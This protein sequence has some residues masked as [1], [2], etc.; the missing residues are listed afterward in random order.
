MIKAVLF[1]LDGTLLPMDQDLFIK[2]YF[3]RLAK[4]LAKRGYDPEQLVSTIWQGT[5]A[6]I[7]NDGKETNETVFWNVF[8]SIFGEKSRAD[9]PYFDEFYRTDFPDVKS[10]C[11]YSP[12]SKELVDKIK[13]R[14]IP[15]VLATNP[16]FPAIATEC[17]I[18]WAGLSPSD[19]SLCTTYENIGYSK[20]NPEYYLEIVRRLGVNADEC[21]MVGNDV[22]DDMIAARL[23][24]KV[25]LLTD[26]LINA[27]NE[28][29]SVYPRGNFDDLF[30]FIFANI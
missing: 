18:G 15:V 17:R 20:P 24:M 23:G 12:R 28:D 30:D 14:G 16:I 8:S 2:T 9:E 1:D 26:C 4:K 13:S 27:K 7:K 3:E 19:F 6:M 5:V 11:G 29:I 21:I 10:V 25:F 22:R